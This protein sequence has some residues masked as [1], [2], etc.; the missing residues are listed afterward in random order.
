MKGITLPPPKS[1]ST[2]RSLPGTILGVISA[3]GAAIFIFFLAL[4]FHTPEWV[5]NFAA[6]FIEK[7]V[8]ER[9]DTAIDSVQAP[10]GTSAL[11]HAAAALYAKNEKK[12]EAYRESLRQNVHER[13]ADAIAKARDLDCD[14]RDKWAHWLKAGTHHEIGLLQKTNRGITDFIQSN[15]AKVVTSLKR[16]IRIFT[17]ANAFVFLLILTL[18]IWKPRASLQLCVPGLLAII[19]TLIC[20]YFYIFQQNWLLTIIF[21]EYLGFTYLV[22]LGVVFALLCDIAM[23]HARIRT[24]IVNAILDAVGS[25]VVATPC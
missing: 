8:S 13:M 22:Y 2:F 15:Y 19:A 20:S 24:G 25:V 10:G 3:L 23:N 1:F 12:I 5:E 7:E 14:C 17:S 6:N 4:T 21:N 18:T 16:D 9:V 11:S